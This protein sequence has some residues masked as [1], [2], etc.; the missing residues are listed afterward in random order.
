MNCE[1]VGELISDYLEGTLGRNDL[2]LV[3]QHVEGCAQCRQLVALARKLES[4]PQEAPSAALSQRVHVLLE[5]YGEGRTEGSPHVAAPAHRLVWA[6]GWLRSAFA[7]VGATAV[8]LIVGFLG[9]RYTANENAARSQQEMASM[10]SELTNM[11][12]LMVLS[13]LQQE[14]A[15]ERLQG[16]SWSTRQTQADPQILAALLRT[17]RY[18]SSVDVRLAALDAL[19]RFG[20][21]PQVRQGLAEALPA[22]QSPLVQVE[23]IDLLVQLHDRSVLDELRKIQ[24]DTT[25]DPAVRQRAERA[26]SELS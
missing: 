25:T 10:E 4:L 8:L 3:E 24:Q 14:S 17:L 1:R 2:S 19:S 12:Q 5:A 21:H 11:R 26:I 20:S 22:Q 16:V 18:D 15:T 23:L 7:A 6:A 13:M 9:G